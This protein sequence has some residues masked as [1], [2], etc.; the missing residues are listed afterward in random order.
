MHASTYHRV[1]T[2]RAY[3]TYTDLTIRTVESNI[4]S[5][6]TFGVMACG[7]TLRV[8]FW[9]FSWDLQRDR[10]VILGINSWT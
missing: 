6:L 3:L 7:L 10:L 4:L 9:R 1:G 8:D 2:L 5:G